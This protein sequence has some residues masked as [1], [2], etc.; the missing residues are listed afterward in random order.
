VNGGLGKSSGEETGG[1]GEM[2]G[3]SGRGTVI[4]SGRVREWGITREKRKVTNGWEGGRR[5][6]DV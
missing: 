1:I 5:G 3:S 2:D 4:A 6:G